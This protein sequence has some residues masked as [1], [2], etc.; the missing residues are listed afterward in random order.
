MVS[1]PDGRAIDPTIRRFPGPQVTIG[2]APECQLVLPD[3]LRIVSRHHA[4]IDL[5][6]DAPSLACLSNTAPVRVNGVSVEPGV[7]ALLRGGDV[8]HVGGFEISGKAP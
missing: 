3:E 5:R 4:R 2:R 6:G 7:A 8:I 1:R